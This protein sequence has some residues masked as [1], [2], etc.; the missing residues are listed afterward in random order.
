MMHDPFQTYATLGSYY[1]TP[2]GQ[3]YLGQGL[4]NPQQQLQQQLQ[5]QQLQQQLQQLQLA[6]A[7]AASQAFNPQLQ[8]LSPLTSV[9]QNPVLAQNPLL[10]AALVNNPLISAGLNPAAIGLA[11]HYGQQSHSPYPQI[12]QIG[13]PFGQIGSP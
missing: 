1:G 4:I 12:G 8:G 9:F 10:L 6:S 11:Q 5:Q 7:L 2:Q 13:S 3:S